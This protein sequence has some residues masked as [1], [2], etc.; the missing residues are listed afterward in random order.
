MNSLKKEQLVVSSLAK[1]SL[2]LLTVLVFLFSTLTYAADPNEFLVWSNSVPGR[3]YVPANYTASKSYPLVIFYHG[4][5]EKGTNNTS[6]VNNNIN[7]LLAE[8]KEREV[9]LYAPQSAGGWWPDS[10]IGKVMEMAREAIATYNIDDKRVYATGLSAGGSGVYNT[11]EVHYNSIAAAVCICGAGGGTRA[12]DDRLV[13]FPIW[14]YHAAND[15]TVSVS[16]TRNA[17]NGIRAEDGRSKL[18]FPLD[19]NPSNPYYNTGSPYYTDG[20]TFFAEDNIRYSE[21]KTG[22]HGIWGRVY[23]EEPMYDWLFSHSLP[24]S[25]VNRA[26]E[27]DAGPDQKLI[28]PMNKLAVKATYLDDGLPHPPALSLKWTKVSGPGSV[29]FDNSTKSSAIATFSIAGTYVI[30]FSVG[31]GQL[32]GHDDV[33]VTVNPPMPEGQVYVISP[34]LAGGAGSWFPLNYAFDRQ[35][36]WDAVNQIPVGGSGGDYAPTYTS[37]QGYIDFGD[38]WA[39]IRIIGT[40]TQYRSSTTGNQSGYAALWWDDDNDNVND[41]GLAENTLK[42]NSAQN[43]T[44]SSSQLWIRDADCSASPITPKGRYLILSSPSTTTSRATEYAFVGYMQTGSTPVNAAPSVNAGSNQTITLPA[45]VS[46][47]G[48]VS[49]DGLP[50]GSITTQWS[51]V[52]GPGTV[53]FANS[54]AVD[55]S[56]NFAA[57]GTYVLRLTANDGELQTADDVT[58][59]VNPAPVLVLR[60]PDTVANPQNGVHFEYY[61]GTW[62][63]LPDFNSLTAVNSGISGNFSIANRN[64][65]DYFGFRFTGFINVAQDGEYTFYTK[66]DDGSQLFIGNQMVV[67]NDGLHGSTEKSG[68]IGLKAGLHAISV[69]FFEKA[70]SE[71]L[72]VNIEGPGLGKTIITDS[73]LYYDAPVN[74]APTVDAGNNQTITLPAIANL[75][76]TVSDDGLPSNSVNTQWTKVS[77]PGAV[78][79]GNAGA[80]DTS[81]NFATAGTYVLRLTANDGE[82]QTSDNVSITVNPE[83]VIYY[84]LT[85][86]SG[87]GDGDYTAGSVVPINADSAPAGQEFDAWIGDIANLANPASASTTVT[88]PTI[89]LVITASYKDI[90]PVDGL[91]ITQEGDIIATVTAPLGGGNH[92][93]NIIRDGDKPEEGNNESKRQ[94]DTFDRNAAPFEEYI[95]YTYNQ[96]FKFSQ[97]VFQEGKHFYDGGFFANGAPRVQVRKNGTWNDVVTV[98]DKPYPIGNDRSEFGTSYETYTFNLNDEEGDGIRLIGQAGG[99]A[100]F[101]SVGEL[102]VFQAPAE[103]KTVMIDF[104]DAGKLTAGNWNNLAGDPAAANGSINDMIDSDGENTGINLQVTDAIASVNSSGTTT[105]DAALGYEANATRDS[106]WGCDKT[107]AGKTEPTAEFVISGLAPAKKYTLSFFASRLSVNDNRET[108][109]T[110]N[111][112]NSS[113]VYLDPAN[114]VDKEV[115]TV[116]ITPDANGEISIDLKKGPNNTNNYGF[117]YIGV[118]KIDF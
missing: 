94:Y 35:P 15:T 12:R 11:M 91:D 51:K 31:D 56:A 33:K 32:T 78:T 47:N 36:E 87:S 26:P 57:A 6:Q 64:I 111:G 29:T 79:F 7:N 43:V 41:S 24:S 72:N 100:H 14:F 2:F 116:P 82:L 27:V 20:S 59:T 85:V 103:N 86:N 30:R 46:L 90:P 25:P 84:N 89:D 10:E 21:Y 97:I 106:F 95:G 48:T 18:T 80:V 107:Y 63:L 110:V 34:L 28:M 19:A 102:E 68:K 23:K 69:T 73:S 109:Y 40:W 65:N 76:A 13:D 53:I 9:F 60:N 75:N 66:S 92:D 62:S 8:C 17:I 115:S 67:D 37:R 113:T 74:V 99:T 70:G 42:F 1:I 98:I 55:T 16:Q 4:I 83:P 88:I 50:S 49:D 5:G 77:G 114:N 58:L 45:A 52:S 44:S 101:I 54:A 104:G 38:N 112:L 117:Y 71:I 61:E 81:A 3:L 39:D 22:G 118:L 96:T 93:I 105:P 108:E